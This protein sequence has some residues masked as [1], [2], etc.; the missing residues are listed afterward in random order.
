LP[1]SRWPC[2]R[3]PSPRAAGGVVLV[4]LMEVPLQALAYLRCLTTVSIDI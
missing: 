4:V 2:S 1:C 3:L